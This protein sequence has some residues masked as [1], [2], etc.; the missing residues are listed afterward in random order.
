MRLVGRPRLLKFARTHAQVRTW[1]A[2]WQREVRAASWSTPQE[3][4]DRYGSVSFIDA[5]LGS[6]LSRDY[7][8][9]VLRIATSPGEVD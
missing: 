7:L 4:K 1:L 8:I 9:N 5:I 2:V 3:V 6:D